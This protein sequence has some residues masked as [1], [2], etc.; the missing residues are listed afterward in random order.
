MKIYNL[1][2]GAIIIMLIAALSISLFSACEEKEQNKSECSFNNPLTDLPW[3]KDRVIQLSQ[4]SSHVRIYQCVYKTNKI[5][6]LIESCVGCPDF[7]LDLTDCQGNY[8][9]TI[10]GFT[11]SDCPEYYV[12]YNDAVLIYERN[13]N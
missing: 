5:G 2:V 12:N 7:G 1:K 6:F 9:C 8:L 10:W 4:E 11:G 13:N 3:L